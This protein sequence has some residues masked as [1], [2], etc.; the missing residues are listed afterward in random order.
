MET[1]SYLSG[2]LDEIGYDALSEVVENLSCSQ[3][4]IDVN[5][6]FEETYTNITTLLAE[7][8]AALDVIAAKIALDPYPPVLTDN[9]WRSDFFTFNT[10]V[11]G[12]PHR[13]CTNC[14]I[15]HPPPHYRIAPK[16]R[17]LD[18]QDE[19]EAVSLSDSS[20]LFSHVSVIDQNGWTRLF[21]GA[22][23]IESSNAMFGPQ[24]RSIY[25]SADVYLLLQSNAASVGVVQAAARVLVKSMSPTVNA[26]VGWIG[27]GD[28]DLTQ[29]RLSAACI[30]TLI[31]VIDAT[32]KE[33]T[34]TA[35][36][37]TNA[38]RN[39]DSGDSPTIVYLITTGF[40]PVRSV[41]TGAGVGDTKLVI[42]SVA[43]SDGLL[44]QQTSIWATNIGV[45]FFNVASI[46]TQSSESKIRNI[47]HKPL[48]YMTGMST[49][50]RFAAPAQTPFGGPFSRPESDICSSITRPV[51]VE[52]SVHSVVAVQM[53]T[54]H[55]AANYTGDTYPVLLT[56]DGRVLSHPRLADYDD[57]DPIDATLSLMELSDDTGSLLT[58]S[59]ATFT[60]NYV[61]FT[62][63]YPLPA[64]DSDYYGSH[65]TSVSGTIRWRRIISN[66]SLP[67]TV[68]TVAVDP[69]YVKP[70]CVHE[71][72]PESTSLFHTTFF[73]PTV[74]NVTAP[75]EIA[76]RYY[77]SLNSSSFVIPASSFENCPPALLYATSCTT[78]FIET[79]TNQTL[80]LPL[81]DPLPQAVTTEDVVS[82]AR[83]AGEVVPIWRDFVYGASENI[84]LVGLASDRSGASATLP[85][86]TYPPGYDVRARTFY[87][88]ASQISGGSLSTPTVVYIHRN[89]SLSTF[90]ARTVNHKD[91][92]TVWGTLFIEYETTQL[93]TTLKTIAD[94]YMPATS[95][96][97]LIDDTGYI[98]QHE[99]MSSVAS[100]VYH[101][102]HNV[103]IS[104]LEPTISAALLDYEYMVYESFVSTNSLE[105][106]KVPVV[107]SE[108]FPESD[109]L[110][111]YAISD[112]SGKLMIGNI[113]TNVI[114]IVAEGYPSLSAT[115]L[116]QCTPIA[117]PEDSIFLSKAQLHA[118]FE[119]QYK[120]TD[121]G[122]AGMSE[123]ERAA[124]YLAIIVG[125]LLL[126]WY[127]MIHTC[128]RRRYLIS[129]HGL[130]PGM[131]VQVTKM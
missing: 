78:S 129:R 50:F 82:A 19:L 114:L 9:S 104:D 24:Y 107:N 40:V 84:L 60:S 86:F 109:S 131:Q 22:D 94:Q 116:I 64:P 115:S 128:N 25:D 117:G 121:D 123:G 66:S 44:N 111:A 118:A 53:C 71:A 87:S 5:A 51:F 113:F 74:Y 26:A 89:S 93:Y 110:R 3:D 29:C 130:N 108:M 91:S 14:T 85:G 76:P 49:H 23:M 16:P 27:Y 96:F 119:A 83:I 77:V 103:H 88:R 95:R 1:H 58:L 98:T 12:I 106:C 55:I 4:D 79:I 31:R 34:Q 120:A 97:M 33:A 81:T 15:F 72:I 21:P 36:H 90:L 10:S 127:I 18:I 59:M 7:K 100:S 124:T 68:A 54:R 43:D 99:T 28:L 65:S 61:E 41:L 125:P 35:E 30:N 80:G 101:F 56:L 69:A 70:A 75:I 67:L 8:Q 73:R 39:I 42:L 20:G 48:D 32:G 112:W 92:E 62:M 13:V 126:L 46:A 17:L 102:S 45:P 37:I 6:L 52:D 122:P 2:Q 47:L 63:N 38:I 11:P 105:I 57:G